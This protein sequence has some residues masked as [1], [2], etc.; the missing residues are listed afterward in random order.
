MKKVVLAIIFVL[1][2]ATFAQETSYGV[3]LGSN[4]YRMPITGDLDSHGGQVP[5]NIGVFGSLQLNESSGLQLNAFY[6]KGTDGSFFSDNGIFIE[7]I[8]VSKFNAQLL[9][10]Y[11]VKKT[12]NQ[13]FHLLAGPR[14]TFVTEAKGKRDHLD[15]ADFYNNINLGLTAGFGFDV[16]KHFNIQAVLDYGLPSTIDF[17]EYKSSTIGAYFNL[18]IDV[19]SIISK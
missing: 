15:Y 2:L 1:S 10:K 19:E 17:G 3:F 5:F 4:F 8:N 7:K 11:H 13:G 14:L 9:Y 18:L 6:G 12:Y 16:L